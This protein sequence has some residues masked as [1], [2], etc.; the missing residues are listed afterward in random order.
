MELVSLITALPLAA[1]EHGAAAAA[2][3]EGGSFLVSP[4]VGLMIWTLIV[5]TISLYVLKKLVFPRIQETLDRR[6][7]AIDD[8][9][10]AAERTRGEAD[11]LLAEY[12]ERLTQAREQAEEILAR[13]R[14]AADAAE[15]AAVT[16]AKAKREEMLEQTKREIQ[17]ETRRAIQDIRNEV[18]DL[19]IL[20]TEKV[21]RKTL[22]E[23]D[24]RRLVEE[25]LGELDFSAL[26]GERAD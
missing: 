3:E 22:T 9:I 1:A 8:S 6:Q 21:T 24:Q 17:A 7:H 12:R 19:T 15:A 11:E 16:D 18:A 5:F 26:A 25:A 20:A 13:A 14:K 23:D 4:N 10:D 2:E